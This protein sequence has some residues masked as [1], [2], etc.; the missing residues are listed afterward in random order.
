[1]FSQKK[2]LSL[3]DV[4]KH[5]KMAELLKEALI[6]CDQRKDLIHQYKQQL[7]YDK[8][9]PGY[10]IQDILSAKEV[11]DAYHFHLTEAQQRVKEH[12]LLPNIFQRD[13]KLP[14]EPRLDITIY[15]DHV[16]SAYNVGSIIRTLESFQLGCLVCGPQTPCVEHK[17]VQDTSMGT[18]Q[19]IQTK[20]I[21]NLK[22]LPRPWI[23]LETAEK[24]TDIFDFPFNYYS[25][26]TLILGNE[27]YG[28]SDK[29][30]KEVDFLIKI[31]MMG[32]K[33]S[34][35][36]ANAFAIAAYEIRRKKIKGR[37]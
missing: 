9:L 23:A 17:K 25:I 6:T 32:R 2:F 37:T 8:N 31:P 18:Y 5:K 11:S 13:R 30:L 14:L 33:N 12:N 26:F 15:L 21:S 16:R 4:Q 29:V 19:W 3:S 27:E 35:N 28:I 22:D 36:I 7:S 24:A 1:M 34:L 20:E 10:P